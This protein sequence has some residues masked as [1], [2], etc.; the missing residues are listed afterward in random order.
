MD[1]PIART[2]RQHTIPYANTAIYFLSCVLFFKDTPLAVN[3]FRRRERRVDWQG[4]KI[5][6][7]GGT[8]SMVAAHFFVTR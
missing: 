6:W 1:D 2:R 8:I 5:V 4:K 7:V 3:T